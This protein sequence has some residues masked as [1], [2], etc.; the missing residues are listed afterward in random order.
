MAIAEDAFRLL[1][2]KGDFFF[3]I[4]Y[5]NRFSHYNANVKKIG[6]NI[7][8]SLSRKWRGVSRDIVI[9]LLQELLIKILKMPHR[10]TINIDLYNNFIRSLHRTSERVDSEPLLFDSFSR[11][12]EK[13]FES[14]IEAPNL[15][16]G[17][18]SRR[19]LASYDYHTDTV[20]VSTLFKKAPLHIVDYLVYHELLHKKLKFKNSKGRSIHHSRQFRKMERAFENSA[21]IE[22]EISSFLRGKSGFLSRLF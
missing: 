22:K 13:Y 11:V 8:F 12:N 14:L 15:V 1:G 6:S 20:T 16:W 18:P 2:G 9:G 4:S 19:K 10:R 7:A 21:G 5:S 3:S 17:R